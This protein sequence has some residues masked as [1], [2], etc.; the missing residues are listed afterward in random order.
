MK[1]VILAFIVLFAAFGSIKAQ[2]NTLYFM[3]DVPLRHSMNPAF[4]PT[5]AWYIGLPS[6]YFE[7]GNSSLM[8]RDFVFKKNNVWTTAFSPSQSIEQLYKRIGSN[9]HTDMRFAL[10]LL[11]FGFRVNYVNYFS[12]DMS[13]KTE[14][15][16]HTPRDLTRLLLFGTGEEGSFDF[17]KTDVEAM[18]YGEL[19]LGYTRK[20]NDKWSAGL[21]VKG[22]LGFAG[23][24]TDIN[25][26]SLY[27]SRQRWNVNAK[28]N[29]YVMAPGMTRNA[30]GSFDFNSA[31]WR[32]LIKP[33]G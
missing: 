12:F 5:S 15:S 7:V 16:M 13:I 18:L 26:M 27:A 32:Q 4:M 9:M 21:K 8:L 31:D 28:A 10:N 24:H 23:I 30:N 6:Y 29:M 22:L 25:N 2:T 19:A 1:K 11:N 3:E 14:T 20:F 33:S 17:K